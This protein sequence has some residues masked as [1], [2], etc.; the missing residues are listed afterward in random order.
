MTVG[1]RGGAAD[2]GCDVR[3]T[4]P[5]IDA[6]RLWSAPRVSTPGPAD[7]GPSAP[8]TSGGPF[9]TQVR[10]ESEA[11]PHVP[12]EIQRVLDIVIHSLY[13]DREIFLRELL[14]NAADAL[15]KLR[16]L[17]TSGQAV[18]QPETAL[19]IQLTADNAAGTLAIAD[20]GSA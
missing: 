7:P 1:D 12:G 15:E 13:T 2:G 20:A 9:P 6:R 18:H 17:Q 5:P 16:F 11:T 8:L 3:M 10:H 19:E 4:P 14:S